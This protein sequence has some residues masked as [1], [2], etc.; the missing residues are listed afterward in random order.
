M[1]D[2]LDGSVHAWAVEALV[3]LKDPFVVEYLSKKLEDG[4][5]DTTQESLDYL[6]Q[7]TGTEVASTLVSEIIESK[8]ITPVVIV[9]LWEK[10]K[11]TSVHTRQ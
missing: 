8:Q 2:R 9:L 3:E 4:S 6:I 5:V 7:A 11:Y 1:V 10:Q